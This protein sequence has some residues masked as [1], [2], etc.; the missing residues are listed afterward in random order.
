MWDALEDGTLSKSKLSG[1]L[2][3]IEEEREAVRAELE[4]TRE[5]ARHEAAR[6]HN[7][8]AILEAFGTGLQ[9]GVVWFPPELR[10]QLYDALGLRALVSPDGSVVLEGSF[11]EATIRLTKEILEYA[12]ALKEAE[13]R[14]REG[15]AKSPATG[16]KVPVTNPDGTP[17]TPRVDAAT[18]RLE[19]L[20]RELGRV[21][22]EFVLRNATSG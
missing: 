14:L 7:R 1:R 19:R 9:L 8:R 4:R 16:Y 11:D 22:R 21:R 12:A 15:E 3:R 13:E 17:G 18:E 6:Q 2:E 5:E 10:R 20:E